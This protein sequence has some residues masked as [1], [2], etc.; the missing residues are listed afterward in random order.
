MQAGT[1]YIYII[2]AVVYVIYSI[3]KA[4]KKVAANK[5]TLDKPQAPSS[6]QPTP[7]VKPPASSPFPQQDLKK[8]LEDI[9]GVPEANVPEPQMV[10][11]KVQPFAEKPQPAKISI[12]SS[13]KKGTVPASPVHPVHAVK[14]PLPRKVIL[15]PPVEETPAID[16]DIRQAIL[17]SEILKRPQY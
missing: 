16:F 1:N 12:D 15:E 5:P 6:A 13:P 17:F 7:T 8:M 10:K 11:P 4:G 9:M 3:I 2:F 14:H